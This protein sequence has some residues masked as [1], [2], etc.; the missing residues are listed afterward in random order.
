NQAS[1]VKT[2]LRQGTEP[3][4]IRRNRCSKKSSPSFGRRTG[5][6]QSRWSKVSASALLHNTVSLAGGDNVVCNF[7]RGG[8][9]RP[10]PAF[11]ICRS[12]WCPGLSQK[13]KLRL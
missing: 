6:K 12:E 4:T 5:P 8:V 1:R 2:R 13:V 7:S 10:E 3:S 9:R 11:G